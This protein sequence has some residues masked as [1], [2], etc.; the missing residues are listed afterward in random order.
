MLSLRTASGKYIP[1]IQFILRTW[2]FLWNDEEGLDLKKRILWISFFVLGL[3][4]LIPTIVFAQDAANKGGETV[5]N[6]G[7][8]I[9]WIL[10]NI[11]YAGMRAQA[12]PSRWWR[13]IAFIFGFPGTL[14]S[15]LVVKEGSE[16]AYGIDIPRRKK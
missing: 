5:G 9:I 15:R 8:S 16:R 10:A 6:G 13:V 11:S 14:L 1:P 12:H 3:F 2:M 4:I 7:V